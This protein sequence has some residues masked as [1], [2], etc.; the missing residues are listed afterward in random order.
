MNPCPGG[1][2]NPPS[3]PSQPPAG[4]GPGHRPMAKRCADPFAL[5]VYFPPEFPPDQATHCTEPIP[6]SPTM[7]ADWIHPQTGKHPDPPFRPAPGSG[8]P[9]A[10]SAR[11]GRLGP[12]HPGMRAVSI[13]WHAATGPAPNDEYPPVPLAFLLLSTPIPIPTPTPIRS[14]NQARVKRPRAGIPVRPR[15]PRQCSA[16]SLGKRATGDPSRSDGL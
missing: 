4:T 10:R 6:S 8:R 14:A 13:G 5:L 3:M 7:R 15:S 2:W 9:V 16:G 11:P 12:A 1:N